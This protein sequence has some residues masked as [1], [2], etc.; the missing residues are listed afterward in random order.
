MNTNK[1]NFLASSN[2]LILVPFLKKKTTYA[3]NIVS[4]FISIKISPLWIMR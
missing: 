1:H 4:R 2:G 3:K